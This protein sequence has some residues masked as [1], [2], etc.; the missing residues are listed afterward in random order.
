[1]YEPSKFDRTWFSH[2]F[3]CVG[4]RWEVAISIYSGDIVWINGPFKC[5]SNPDLRIFR[6]GLKQLLALTS[7][8]CEADG[9]Y[10][11][12]PG[13]VNLP[14]AFNASLDDKQD[15]RSRHETCNKRFK[16]FEILHR[17]FRH[18]TDYH[19]IVFPAVAVLTQLS[20]ENGSPLY[21]AIY[22]HN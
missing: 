7:E 16:Q 4:L 5:G 11:G 15:V 9:G 8:R 3:K 12:E 6:D 10:R 19:E 20:I 18:H 13:Y 17:V 14:A 1:M 22:T 2:K 21:D